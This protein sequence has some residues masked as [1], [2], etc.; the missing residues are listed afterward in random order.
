[1][2]LS[3]ICIGTGLYSCH[4]IFETDI[5]KKRVNV[6]APGD[7]VVLTNTAV[8]FWWDPVDYATQYTVQV[9][10]PNFNSI[11]TLVLDSTVT[12]NKLLASLG[13]GKYQW[14]IRAG[15]G[16]SYTDFQ[17]YSFSIDSNLNIINQTVVLTS[18]QSNA[19]LGTHTVQ[20]TWARV[21][22]ATSYHFVL[23]TS[24][25]VLVLDTSVVS[26]TLLYGPIA[27]GTY[28]WQ[29]AA[30]NVSGNTQASSAT[31]I[32]DSIAPPTPTGFTASNYAFP[33]DSFILGW[34]R[35]TPPSGYTY[36]DTLVI[37]SDSFQNNAVRNV[38][39]TSASPVTYRDSLR[40]GTYYSKVATKNNT[41]NT[42]AFTSLIRMVLP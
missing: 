38:I 41:G 23:S 35:G 34:T 32:I 7:S 8:T 31:F 21:Y 4:D 16:S 15:N 5:S 2:V 37:F 18:P 28:T 30:M 22:P 11:Q 20:F 29:V 24:T 10:Q 1:M 25:A 9:V 14:R 13:P 3:V 26:T 42:S 12:T 39:I 6:L 27:D 17:T 40:S 33:S 19:I 36:Y